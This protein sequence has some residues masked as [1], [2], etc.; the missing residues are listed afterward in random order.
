MAVLGFRRRLHL[1]EDVAR[2]DLGLLPQ[3]V[4]VQGVVGVDLAVRHGHG[5]A[6]LR[7]EGCR[8]GALLGD[9]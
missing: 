9:R 6:G 2:A 7:V 1:D 4:R 8:R 5:A 3:L